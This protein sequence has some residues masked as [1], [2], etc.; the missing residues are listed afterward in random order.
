MEADGNIPKVYHLHRSDDVDKRQAPLDSS[1]AAFF[2]NLIFCTFVGDG[3]I[4]DHTTVLIKIIDY[5]AGTI[6]APVLSMIPS[7]PL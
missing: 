4:F 6:K 5:F 1:G 2:V 3:F 7:L